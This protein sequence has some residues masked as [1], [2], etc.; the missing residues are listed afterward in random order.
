[1]SPLRHE[2]L[3]KDKNCFDSFRNS[4]QSQTKDNALIQ[5]HFLEFNKWRTTKKVYK[6]K[7]MY[8]HTSVP[9]GIALGS[10][11]DAVKVIV[12]RI[13]PTS[14]LFKLSRKSFV[15]STINC[16]TSSKWPRPTLLHFCTLS[17]QEQNEHEKVPRCDIG[18][19]HGKKRKNDLCAFYV[20]PTT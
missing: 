14:S 4:L 5:E 9:A 15:A 1:M 13:F 16:K 7:Q 18:R 2:K 3:T 11:I 8:R 17:P 12:I 19:R 6:W 20:R 10:A